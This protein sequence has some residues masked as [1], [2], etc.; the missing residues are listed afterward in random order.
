MKQTLLKRP[1]LGG[2]GCVRPSTLEVQF[3]RP[4]G[5]YALLFGVGDD[6]DSAPLTVAGH[7]AALTRAFLLSPCH[8]QLPWWL[9]SSL[10]PVSRL[11]NDVLHGW[12]DADHAVSEELGKY[13]FHAAF[14]RRLT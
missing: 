2:G 6:V 7:P 1:R 13:E 11:T 12:L 3:A 8:L 5:C 4:R 9:A 10:R 14:G